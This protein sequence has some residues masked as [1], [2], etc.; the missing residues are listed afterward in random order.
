[1]KQ[2]LRMSVGLLMLGACQ[3]L[4]TS[5]EYVARGDGFFKDGKNTYTII[6]A[7]IENK[8]AKEKNFTVF[9]IQYSF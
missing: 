3:T 5:A 2:I 9:F 4:P 1:M 6:T 7:N 8:N